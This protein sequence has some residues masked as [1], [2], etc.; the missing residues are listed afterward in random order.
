MH[1]IDN[2]KIC[3]SIYCMYGINNQ[4]MLAPVIKTYT[5]FTDNEDLL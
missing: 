5:H 1:S 4:T 2:R 3:M